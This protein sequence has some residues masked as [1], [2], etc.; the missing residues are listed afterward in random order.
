MD[1]LSHRRMMLGTLSPKALGLDLDKDKDN[2]VP[3]HGAA[4]LVKTIPFL[5]LVVPRARVVKDHLPCPCP[6]HSRC[7]NLSL[8]LLNIAAIN[9]LDS[10]GRQDN[11]ARLVPLAPSLVE[12]LREP[13][14]RTHDQLRPSRHSPLPSQLHRV[15][16]LARFYSSTQTPPVA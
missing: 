5:S 11:Q 15:N 9:N 8:W 16:G 1:R 10:R 7:L 2:R 13:L 6:L 3:A 14:H 4:P 12:A